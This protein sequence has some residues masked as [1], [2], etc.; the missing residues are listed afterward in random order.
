MTCFSLLVLAAGSGTGMPQSKELREME[1]SLR[2]PGTYR[3]PALDRLSFPLS[4][5]S[6]TS[7]KVSPCSRVPGSPTLIMP[8]APTRLPRRKERTSLRLSFGAAHEY[9][10]ST[11]GQ[12]GR[13]LSLGH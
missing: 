3:K 10:E 11:R 4:N 7:A 6:L 9:P 1:R 2:A 12:T 8:A 5:H 13:L